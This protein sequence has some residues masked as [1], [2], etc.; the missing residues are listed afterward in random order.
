[1][2]ITTLDGKVIDNFDGFIGVI[3][4]IQKAIGPHQNIQ[5]NERSDLV[6][7]V[8]NEERSSISSSSSSS[9]TPPKLLF[10]RRASV[11]KK[12]PK[13]SPSEKSLQKK[14]ESVLDKMAKYHWDGK[15]YSDN[16]DEVFTPEFTKELNKLLEL[17][18]T[19]SPQQNNGNQDRK[20]S[21][22]SLQLQD[23]LKWL[24]SAMNASDWVHT[25]DQQP[26][27]LLIRQLED[28]R[29]CSR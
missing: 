17:L 7:S 5:S 18:K 29:R 28:Q 27:H 8:G 6:V 25:K 23:A 1:M 10:K 26:I 20:M 9:G 11:S 14:I 16:E 22:T 24:D 3:D 12:S 19:A 13:K 15:I 4:K 2:K 21:I